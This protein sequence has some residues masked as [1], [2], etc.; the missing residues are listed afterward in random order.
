MY[1]EKNKKFFLSLA[2]SVAKGS[3]KTTLVAVYLIFIIF[4]ALVGGWTKEANIGGETFKQRISKGF[5]DKGPNP[6]LFTSDVAKKMAEAQKNAFIDTLAKVPEDFK[7]SKE[8]SKHLRIVFR[9]L[10]A[11]DSQRVSEA[12]AKIAEASDMKSEEF[13]EKSIVS[14]GGMTE[15]YEKLSEIPDLKVS[16]DGARIGIEA[17]DRLRSEGKI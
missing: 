2:T 5:D 4:G 15:L 8:D 10:A 12:I 14:P 1:K 16:M 3:L 9:A 6:P 7:L 13:I 11:S 17:G